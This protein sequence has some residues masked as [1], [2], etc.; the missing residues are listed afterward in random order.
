[1]NFPTLKEPEKGIPQS[2]GPY[3]KQTQLFFFYKIFWK[4]IMFACFNFN[5]MFGNS[6]ASL[7]NRNQPCCS[8]ERNI[9]FYN[10][11][12]ISFPGIIFLPLSCRQHQCH[13]ISCLRS[14]FKISSFSLI[15]F[16][17]S[18]L[19][20]PVYISK[21]SITDFDFAPAEGHLYLHHTAIRIFAVH[22]QDLG[23][24]ECPS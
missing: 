8:P 12:K 22:L 6:L 7:W 19:F 9:F 14:H 3:T 13:S 21:V 24:L 4:Y 17:I 20:W 18:D 1:M 2:Q 11:I 5:P 10:F 16:S 23:Y 15:S